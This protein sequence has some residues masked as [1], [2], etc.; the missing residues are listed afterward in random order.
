MKDQLPTPTESKDTGWI[1]VDDA[2]PTE[3]NVMY[4]LAWSNGAIRLFYPTH[5][6]YV[7]SEIKDSL[8]TSMGEGRITHWKKSTPINT[9]LHPAHNPSE[10]SEY[11][12]G[13]Q[14]YLK[15]WAF[16]KMPAKQTREDAVME[17]IESNKRGHL[18]S[19]GYYNLGESSR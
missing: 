7:L 5:L 14:E 10:I 15:K 3:S 18:R 6:S 4:W 11:S 9:P 16:S 17:W 19:L 12:K 13:L 1:S 8:V 2:M